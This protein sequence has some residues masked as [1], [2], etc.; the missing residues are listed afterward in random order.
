MSQTNLFPI[1]KCY[2]LIYCPVW[3][4]KIVK[5]QNGSSLVFLLLILQFQSC[6]FIFFHYLTIYVIFGIFLCST[7]CLLIKYAMYWKSSNFVASVEYLF[8][9]FVQFNY[10]TLFD[11][12]KGKVLYLSR[13]FLEENICQDLVNV[14]WQFAISIVV[15]WCVVKFWLNHYYYIGSYGSGP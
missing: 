6:L 10:S 7:G 8:M 4:M 13:L 3:S 12:L 2:E 1:W 15:G 9:F 5:D 11:K 14:I